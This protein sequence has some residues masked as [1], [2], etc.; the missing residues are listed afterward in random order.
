MAV[1][2]GGNMLSL[3]REF[4]FRTEDC[5]DFSA[6][7]NPLGLSE[8][9]RE[10][11][12]QNLD[13]ILHYPDVNYRTARSYLAAY[14]GVNEEQIL[15]SNGAVELF[16][17]LA[18]Q[19]K[20]PKVLLL[21][22]T[23]MEY[24]RAFSLEGTTFFYHVLKGPEFRWSLESI[25]SDLALL[26]A[27][28][29]VLICNPNNPTGSL[30]TGLELKKL[31]QLLQQ[32]NIGLI[33]DE[34]F[35]DFTKNEA[36]YTLISYLKDLPN[37][38]VVRSLTKFYALPGLRLGYLV[39]KNEQLIRGIE[40]FKPPWTVNALSDALVPVILEDKAYKDATFSWLKAEQKFLYSGLKELSELD[41]TVPS[42]NYI[43]FEYKGEI[44][45]RA[46]LRQKKIFIRSCSN[47]H[48]LT[49]KYYRIAIR[50]RTEN[51]RLLKVLKEL[52][53]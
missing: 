46:A 52:L 18:R 12:L 16:Y 7:I 22:P 3:A 5:L 23:F 48:H 29:M 35:V 30:V 39:T 25:K 33:V 45:L 15:L 37:A 2:H 51:Q 1:E 27:G 8:R 32:R 28:D 40:G 44:D 38:I 4:G 41:V 36:T 47:Y 34:A 43:F 6:N 20:P 49:D 53:V 31:A 24:E 9:A 13:A 14:H 50:N 11:I 26:S 21:S 19:I 17:D 42:A 10:C